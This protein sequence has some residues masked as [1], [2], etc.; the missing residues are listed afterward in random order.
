MA[1]CGLC[2][3]AQALLGRACGRVRA[4]RR[5]DERIIFAVLAVLAYQHS[6]CFLQP[7]QQASTAF[8]LAIRLAVQRCFRWS[9]CQ[10]QPRT[11][12]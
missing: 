12:G 7:L 11:M 9:R 3:R 10:L 2:G 6:C 1:V 4:M 5:R 8:A